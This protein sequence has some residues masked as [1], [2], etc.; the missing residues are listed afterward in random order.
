MPL[1]SNG[2]SPLPKKSIQEIIKQTDYGSR[3]LLKVTEDSSLIE[4]AYSKDNDV[5]EGGLT[6]L[7]S[8]MLNSE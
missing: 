6:D 7:D 1:I 4:S 3:R 2:Q 8:A 5:T